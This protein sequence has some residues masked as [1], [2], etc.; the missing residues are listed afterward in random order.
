MN[1]LSLLTMIVILTVVWGGLALCLVTA[2][3]RERGKDDS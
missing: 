1:P 3:R 2:L